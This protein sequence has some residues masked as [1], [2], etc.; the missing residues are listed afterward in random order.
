MSAS[1][2]KTSHYVAWGMALVASL[3]SV[4]FIEIVGNAAATL[5]WIERMLIFGIFLVLSVGILLKDER[6]HKYALPFVVLGLPVALF[7]QLVHWDIIKLAA[8][9][10]SVSVVCT[11]KFFDLFGFIS[12]ATLCLTA[13]IVI[14][15]CLYMASRKG[16]NQGGLDGKD[17]LPK[18]I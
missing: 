17:R 16:S 8:E 3:A 18:K 10:C 4:Y 1:T 6:M 11:T 5:C 9:S 2:I 15:I 12:Q 13:Y 7:Q 14:G